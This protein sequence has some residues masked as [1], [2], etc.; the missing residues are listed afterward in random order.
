MGKS[1]GLKIF[2]VAMVLIIVAYILTNSDFVLRIVKDH[3]WQTKLAEVQTHRQIW[4]KQKISTYKI[5]IRA[6]APLEC[7]QE[8]LI[9]NNAPVQIMQNNC[10][11]YVFFTVETLF[12]IM[13][14]IIGE[15]NC[16]LGGC[17][18]GRMA[19]DVVYDEEYKFPKIAKSYYDRGDW[20]MFENKAGWFSC[21]ENAYLYSPYSIDY[22]IY[23]F[24]PTE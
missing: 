9:H 8:L 18:C 12:A 22:E 20:W 6:I 3:Y 16:N 13:E 5:G 1:K 4:S 14:K 11:G 17:H 7:S 15:R 10:Y 19:V 2:L 23:S 21:W 24:I